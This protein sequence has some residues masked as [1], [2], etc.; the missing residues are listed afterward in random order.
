[1]IVQTI[2]QLRRKSRALVEGVTAATKRTL[3]YIANPG[4]FT[5]CMLR[6]TF[7]KSDSAED[8]RNTL[9]TELDIVITGGHPDYRRKVKSTCAKKYFLIISCLPWFPN[10]VGT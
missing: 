2:Y 5:K 4:P 10:K 7:S 8:G 6:E 1:M 3:Q 9:E